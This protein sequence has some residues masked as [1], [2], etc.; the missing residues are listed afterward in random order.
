M[1]MRVCVRTYVRIY[2]HVRTMICIYVYVY[3]RV[4]VSVYMR[5]CEGVY[6]CFVNTCVIACLTG[7]AVIT[8][9]CDNRHRILS[10][11]F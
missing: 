2:M 10:R 11:W 8:Q 5:V 6:V 4:C 3:V 7:S 1:Y 9:T